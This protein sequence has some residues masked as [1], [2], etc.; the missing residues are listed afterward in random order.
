MRTLLTGVSLAAM[1]AVGSPAHAQIPVT[2]GANLVAQAKNLLQE[3]KSYATQLQQLQQQVQSVMWAE[4]TA[5]SFIQNPNLGSAMALMNMVGIDNPLPINPYSVQSLV[6]GYGGMNSLSGLTGKLGALNGLVTNSYSSDQIYSCTD[7]SYACARQQQVAY[8][9]AGIKGLT[10]QIYQQ[11]AEH[12]PVLQ[13][14]RTQLGTAPD[15]AQREQIL[16]QLAIENTWTANAQGQLQTV[17]ALASTQDNVL[18]AQDSE[19]VNQSIDRLLASAP[20]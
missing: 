11:L 3:L 2:D 17:M 14:L 4:Q 19:R 15:P 6:S 9:N 18:R 13:S 12:I 7:G 10:S 1:I 5:Q 8:S 16:A 20:K